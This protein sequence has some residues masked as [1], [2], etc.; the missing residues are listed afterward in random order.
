MPAIED[1]SSSASLPNFIFRRFQKP[2]LMETA[3]DHPIAWRKCADLQP[4]GLA[5]IQQSAGFGSCF[6]HIWWCGR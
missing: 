6:W 5:V 4:L 1:T 3:A 2:K